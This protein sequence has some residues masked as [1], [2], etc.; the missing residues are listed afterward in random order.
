MGSLRIDL[1]CDRHFDDLGTIGRG[2]MASDVT[3]EVVAI[4]MARHRHEWKMVSNTGYYH[5][6]II[7]YSRRY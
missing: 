6:R 1:S 7:R 5:D 2:P 3:D 4:D